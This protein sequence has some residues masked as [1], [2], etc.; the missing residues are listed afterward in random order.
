MVVWFSQN[1]F[2]QFLK[3]V[4]LY[5]PRYGVY[6]KVTE[7]CNSTWTLESDYKWS[8]GSTTSKDIWSK[9]EAG[10]NLV[11]E[12]KSFWISILIMIF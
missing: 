9:I 11:L 3:I 10:I 5:L 7:G 6:Y 12:Y 2:S 1:I 4:P 8:G